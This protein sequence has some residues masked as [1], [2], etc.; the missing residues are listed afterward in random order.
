[1]AQWTARAGLWMLLVVSLSTAS[2]AQRQ[3]TATGVV[4]R[5]TSVRNGDGVEILRQGSNRWT[6]YTGKNAHLNPGDQLRTGPDSSAQ[7]QINGT[8]LDVVPETQL[9]FLPRPHPSARGRQPWVRHM[10]GRIRVWLV[11]ERQ[12]VVGTEA[13]AA[14][15]EGTMFELIA[16]PDGT[17]ILTVVEG[18]VEFSNALGAVVVN[19]GQQSSATPDTAP[20]RPVVIP[21]S[22]V[23]VWEASL[24]SMSTGAEQLFSGLGTDDE[25]RA[26]VGA[27]RA[28]AA[29]TA[30]DL[31]RLGDALHDAGEGAE[32]VTAYERALAAGA[33][34]VA[35][36]YRAG[37]ALTREGRT[38]EA[39]ARFARL[40][41][42]AGG[43]GWAQL[44]QAL[45]LLE[46][47]GLDEAQD[48][49]SRL[50]ASAANGAPAAE[51]FA[52]QGLAYMRSGDLAQATSA[53]DRA[54]DADESCYQ[55]QA[56]TTYARL[57]AGDTAGALEASERALG[58]AP[59]S[60]L[61]HEARGY[62]LF[63]SGDL[64]GAE[65]EV[66]SAL[67]RDPQRA[68][69]RE[70]LADV[71]LAQGD[72]EEGILAAQQAVAS[73]P[74]SASGFVKLGIGFLAGRD[75]EG[76]ERAFGRALE[77]EE[78]LVSAH[79]GL[80]V[81]Y[82]ARGDLAAA[83]QQQKAA[84][85]LD[86]H[87][88]A[89]HNNLGVIHTAQGRLEQALAAFD[90]AVELQPSWGL[91]HGNRAIALLDLNRFAD[92]AREAELAVRLGD[93]SA[94]LYTTLARVY[95]EQ[96][97]FGKALAALRRAEALDDTHALAHL[98][99]AEI[100]S[101]RG[102][103]RDALKSQ[104][105]AVTLDPGAMVETR[106]Y[107]R[108]E[109]R[110]AGGTHGR[111]QGTV[112]TDGRDDEGRVSYF[113]RVMHDETD[114]HRTR[115]DTHENL[116]LGIWGYEADPNDQ[117]ILYTSTF[118]ES[119]ARPGQETGQG[120][121]FVDDRGQFDGYEV[122]LLNRHRTSSR[123]RLTSKAG[124]RYSRL[125]ESNPDSLEP[126]PF[127]AEDTKP[128]QHLRLARKEALGE[129]RYDHDL[130]SRD[131][132][133]A[134]VAVRDGSE[135]FDGLAGM[136]DFSTTPPTFERR[137]VEQR[138]PG[139]AATL[140]LQDEHR[141]SDRL[142]LTF[143]GYLGAR[144]GSDTILRPK[145]LAH[146]RPGASSDIVLVTYPIFRDDVTE[147]L[148]VESWYGP[149]GLRLLGFAEGGWAQSTE[150]HWQLAPA[151]ASLLRLSLAYRTMRGQLIDVADPRLRPMATRLL[152]PKSKWRSAEIEYE[153]WLARRLSGRVFAR[154]VDADSSASGALPYHPRT[155]AGAGLD[156]LDESGIRAGL[157]FQW[158]SGRWHDEANSVRVPSYVLGRL[159]FS[160]QFDLHTEVF[161]AIDNLLDEDYERWRGYPE[162]GRIFLG[163]VEY[164]YR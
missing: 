71:L 110:L 50:E 78:G 154:F 157:Q 101:R 131:T 132:V 74:R 81:V 28:Q 76:A 39:A 83:L 51:A 57:A 153:R 15:A 63:F 160:K 126:D 40:E 80:G 123:G 88:A 86:A 136:V 56:Y 94:I 112:K 7:V 85:A 156:Y 164:R 140:Y 97:R 79:V 143:G 64:S 152:V 93:R 55:A 10:L 95:I 142:K 30:D 21:E 144:E 91:P 29:P 105:R 109:A 72:V 158:V 61:A 89:A 138:Y 3:V 65:R 17:T 115:S 59:L 135:R 141:F 34:A 159:R 104:L 77:R 96:D 8:R 75:Y 31:L 103:D 24:P 68:T 125:G 18:A 20:T 12:F 106:E 22:E 107:S 14:A 52:F 148:P 16:L 43:Q 100:Y 111:F 73:D 130:T 134:G 90:R 113:A 127:S 98:K 25:L 2:F 33:D 13:A 45:L 116:A 145:A 129:F 49:A 26:A 41:G 99:L 161:V 124:Y 133:T 146:W 102:R 149:Q 9:L 4:G 137:M 36:D 42:R 87:A 66:L 47:G 32:A 5:V 108:T 62:A 117:W 69:A 163:G 11:G 27:G 1:M 35:A 118:E 121:E 150:L 147:L 70:L 119:G 37:C 60:A 38:D 46:H 53:L 58:L 151:D 44:G 67:A 155:T 19:A 82:E 48:A 139:D 114:G 23:W 122:H 162:P 54:R 128:F 92:A 84:V 6:A 120:P